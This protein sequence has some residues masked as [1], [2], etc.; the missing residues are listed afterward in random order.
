MSE[1]TS[2]GLG[3]SSYAE[4]ADVLSNIGI[5]VREHRRMLRISLR[6]AA[7]Q[8]DTDA[9][10]LGRIEA[11]K[12]PSSMTLLGILRWLDRAPGEVTP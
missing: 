3:L 1:P 10:T 11:G 2:E 6:E 8:A 7:R 9:S 12:Q 4:L 5:I